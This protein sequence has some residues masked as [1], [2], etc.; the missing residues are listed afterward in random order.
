MRPR[1]SAGRRPARNGDPPT[2]TRL[3]P[4]RGLKQ[5]RGKNSC[6]AAPACSPAPAAWSGHRS[7]DAYRCRARLWSRTRRA[8]A[9]TARWSQA[10]PGAG[11]RA[12]ESSAWDVIPRACPRHAQRSGYGDEYGYAGAAR[13]GG[14]GGPARP[15]RVTAPWTC[16]RSAVT[17]RSRPRRPC[18]AHGCACPSDRRRAPRCRG[19][20]RPAGHAAGTGGGGA[21]SSCRRR[22]RSAGP[23]RPRARARCNPRMQCRVGQQLGHQEQGV[24]G[25]LGPAPAPVEQGLAREVAALGHGPAY[26]SQGEPTALPRDGKPG[27]P[28]IAGFRP[29]RFHCG[30]S[31]PPLTLVSVRGNEQAPWGRGHPNTR[32][33]V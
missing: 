18:R 4:N 1:I 7:A 10:G 33:T 14:T 8:N 22:P 19:R 3:A 2:S 5:D 20:G 12:R 11:V 27:R 17:P 13:P 29:D 9:M 30:L 23:H 24:L 25:R 6:R 16:P 15:G 21:A 26:A 31:P 32:V 28:T